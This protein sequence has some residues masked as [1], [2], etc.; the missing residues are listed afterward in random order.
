MQGA[1]R[2]AAHN[3]DAFYIH[4][5]R[6]RRSSRSSKGHTRCSC[7]SSCS[8]CSLQGRLSLFGF[9][10]EGRQIECWMLVALETL[11]S[12]IITQGRAPPGAPPGPHP[13]ATWVAPRSHPA[14]GGN[15]VGP[16]WRLGGARV[17]H[18]PECHLGLTGLHPGAPHKHPVSTWVPPGPHPDSRTDGAASETRIT[19]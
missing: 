18:T 17:A 13:T 14:P 11:L 2:H 16:R 19:R 12:R 6:T 15:M 3:V 7:P 9:M 4:T 1:M 8:P 10:E 5:H